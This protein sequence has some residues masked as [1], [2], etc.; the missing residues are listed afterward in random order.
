MKTAD[1]NNRLIDGY[2]ELLKNLDPKSKLDLISKLTKSIKSDL[3][4]K[5]K[6]FEKAFGAWDKSEDAEKIT[7]EIRDSRSFNRK[8]EDLQAII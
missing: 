6:T 7:K 5:S 8:I 1:F 3:K 4:F 2:L